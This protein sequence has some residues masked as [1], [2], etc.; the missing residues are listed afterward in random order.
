MRRLI[1]ILAI[2]V[3]VAAVA[4]GWQIG[5]AYVENY[6]FG[7]DLNDLAVQNRARTG[8]ES[9]A[10]E[11]ELKSAAMASA[12]QHG[13]QLALDHLTVH[14]TL[15]PGTFSATGIIETP[16]NLDISIAAEYDALVHLPGISFS[17]HF[18]PAASHNAAVIVK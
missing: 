13:I 4:A 16:A 12:Q 15:T 10:T 14:R 17:I 8:L 1:L 2:G 5:N 6:E 18:A 11:D 9:I 3:A 7:S